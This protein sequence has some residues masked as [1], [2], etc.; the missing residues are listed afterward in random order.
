MKGLNMKIGIK[1]SITIVLLLLT[2]VFALPN[3]DYQIYYGNLHSHTSYSDGRGTPEQA[4]A[5]A[6]KY[7]DVLAV[8]DH[9][10]F[11]KIPV[12]G[13]SK[14]YLTQQAARSAT[15]PGK[16]VGLQG[17]EWTA[18][19]GHINVYETLEFISRDEKGDLKDFYEWI[20]K[21]KKL[22]QF[23]HP[24]VTFGNFQ[25][26]WFW[27][28]ADKYVNLIEVGNG[29]WSSADVISEEMFNNFILAL[30]RGWHLSPTANQDNHKE[31]WASA[32]DAR[33]GILAKSLIYEDIMEALWN[34]RTFASEDKNAK[35]YFYADNNIMGSILP[36]REKANFYIYYS[37]KGDPVS[38]VYIFSQSK[39]YELPELSGKDEF[40]YSATFDI[41][42]GYEWFFVY[43]I[44]KDGNEIV[45]APVWFETDSPFRVNYVRVGPEKPSV[46]Q[47]VQITFDIYN[48]SENPQQGTL[49]VLLNG[50]S[51]YSERL[52]LKPY[53]IEYDKN[54]Q[55]G[56]LEAGDTRV[57]FLIDDK[58]VQS[59][60]IKV[61]E[62]RG[63][64][65]LVDKLHENDVGDE[66]L[67]L[68]RK[69]EEQGNTVIFADTVLKDYN[70]VD[71][72][73]IPT[74]KQGGLDFFKDL[75][76]DEIEW[77]RAFKGQLILLK[78]SDEEYFERYSELIQ[79][80]SVVNSVEELAN[81]L[82]VSL[83]TSKQ[84][85]QQRKVVYIDQ[86][87]SNDYY[88]DKLSKLE[89]FLKTKGFEVAYIDKIQA[90]DGMYLIIMNGKGYLDDEVR[91][92][93]S[94]VKNGGIL[95]I[96]SKSDYNNGGN[97]E[98]LNA[99]LDALNSPVRFNDDQVVD[100]IN[101]YGANYKVIAGNVRFYSP[102]SLL[103]Y[104]NAQVLISSET[105]KSVDSDG[106]NDAQPVDKIILAATFKSGLGKVVVL[107]KAVFSDFD[108][109]LNKEFIQNVLFDVK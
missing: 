80:A 93:V 10:Y 32:N 73:L 22:A 48:V 103:L 1:L 7:A 33:T 5:H 4:Y 34:R 12:N 104:G 97:T 102:C 56:K 81:I 85:T 60:V 20:T 42:D 17:F 44:Q 91:N 40:Q 39:I 13:Q 94:F 51:V 45:S 89:S 21:V 101:N 77:L 29:N 54:I 83:P 27:P 69:F 3:F 98:D 71:I 26:F 62:K 109:E 8:T 108:Y 18:G 41:V 50:K 47:N 76:P 64:T 2:T 95:I 58:N 66:L 11:L 28:E 38:K 67:S 107:G 90:I 88:K 57:D 35:L 63:L 75:M 96:T 25:D 19:S 14:T 49:T 78:G 74:P 6:S 99:I 37:D 87:H 106:K 59:V 9:C 16:F 30:N 55:L 92:I 79:N 24:G 15:I 105:A 65:V 23:N 100:E 46:N 72:V 84:M 86:G 82:G 53:G 70:D 68:L 36:Y 43:I 31:N 52:S 61:S